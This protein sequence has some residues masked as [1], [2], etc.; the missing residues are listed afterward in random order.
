M[1]LVMLLG[2]LPT[3]GSAG[4]IIGDATGDI[5]VPRLRGRL[6]AASKSIYR[7]QTFDIRLV[8]EIFEILLI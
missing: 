3:S 6:H 8:L 7:K 1:S 2:I 5:T 4:D